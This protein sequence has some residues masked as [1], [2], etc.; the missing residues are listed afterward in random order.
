LLLTSC[1]FGIQADLPGTTVPILGGE[2]DPSIDQVEINTRLTKG[3]GA[4]YTPHD[5][6][7]SVYC[8]QAPK[9]N[10]LIIRISD[11]ES[12]LYISVSRELYTNWDLFLTDSKGTEVNIMD[13][14][15]RYYI[16]VC[17]NEEPSKF[18]SYEARGNSITFTDAAL[19]SLYNEI[20]N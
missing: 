4:G 16:Y 13:P 19:F 11:L 12:D 5:Q 17:P 20:I 15:G 8:L 2:C 3:Y 14:N 7:C 6:P 18:W 9:G 10:Q 1:G